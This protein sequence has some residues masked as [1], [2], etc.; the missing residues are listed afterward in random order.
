MCRTFDAI[1]AVK[2]ATRRDQPAWVGG[3]EGK[4][5]GGVDVAG[6]SGGGD[7]CSKE[8]IDNSFAEPFL[9]KTCTH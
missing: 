8:E 4:G 3:G 5:G 2:K 1:E 9:Y 7:A 6:G